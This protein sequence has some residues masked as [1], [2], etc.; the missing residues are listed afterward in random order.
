MDTWLL[1]YK[2]YHNC[3]TLVYFHQ[4]YSCSQGVV[5]DIQLHYNLQDCGSNGDIVFEI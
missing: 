2:L 5:E 3:C 1:F 4:I